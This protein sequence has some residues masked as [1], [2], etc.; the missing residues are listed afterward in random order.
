METTELLK[1]VRKL[2]IKTKGMVSQL[3]S[4]EYH[5]AFKGR[6]ISFS[7]V[8]E[9]EVGDEIRSI[10]WNVTARMNHPYV[11]VFEEERELA[12]MMMVDVSHSAMFGTQKEFKR[13][14]MAEVSALLAYSAIRNNDKVGLI[15]FSDTIEKFV[16]PQK[17]NSHL[18][19]IIRELLDVTPVSKKTNIAS[20]LQYLNNVIKKKCVVF[21]LSDFMNDGFEPMLTITA[22]KH[23]VVGIHVYD[24]RETALPDIGLL[25][26]QDAETGKIICI[27]TGSA[28]LRGNYAGKFR[29]HVQQVTS[30]LQ[31]CGIDFISIR[32]GD[33]YIRTL[34]QLFERRAKKN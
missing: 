32:T 24:E 13:D 21:V 20:A 8:R 7:E 17:G 1:K 15:L 4:G 12:V 22:R 2:E 3:F 23:D 31:R 10:D 27:D 25:Q 9:Y 18:L 26:V 34:M 14:L 6:G 28:A 19:R 16:P 5:S 11:K 29:Q 30:V 33:H